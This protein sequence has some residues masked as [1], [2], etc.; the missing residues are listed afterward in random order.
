VY[1]YERSSTMKF[2]ESLEGRLAITF[3]M[4]TSSNKKRGYMA[5][6]AHYI[7]GNWTLHSQILR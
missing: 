2:I 3:D 5:V 4:W 6:I 7:D 1:E